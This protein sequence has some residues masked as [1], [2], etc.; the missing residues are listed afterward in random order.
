MKRNPNEPVFLFTSKKFAHTWSLDE[1]RMFLAVDYGW[2]RWLSLGAFDLSV[3]MPGEV[4]AR[5][6]VLQDGHIIDATP[7]P[8]GGIHYE[9]VTT[10][11]HVSSLGAWELSVP[12]PYEFTY[13][14]P[15]TRLPHMDIEPAAQVDGEL[16]FTLQL[17]ES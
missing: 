15:D 11:L 1:Y 4:A 17:P 5:M 16:V 9:K 12:P 3:V 8:V 7:A 2:S 10:S 6:F 13:W 14:R